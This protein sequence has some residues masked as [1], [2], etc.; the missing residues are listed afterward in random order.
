M[1]DNENIE[2][3]T[4]EPKKAIL[5]LSMP[6]FMTLIMVF[7]YNLVDT[8][9]VAGLG[10]DAL[11][12]IAFVGPI[13]MLVLSIG[14][15]IGA[16][17]SSLI[18]ISIG[19]N[20]HNHANN[21]GLHAILLGGVLSII[22]AL[23]ILLYAKPILIWIG[24]GNVLSYAMDYIH[25]IFLFL[26]VFIYSSIG[27]S[28]FRAEGNVKRATLAV[29]LGGILDII[30]D[31]IFIYTFNLG[32][33]GAAIATVISALISCALMAY[34]VWIKKDN[35]LELTYKD[36]KLDLN[37]IK[38]IISLAIPD[39]LETTIVSALTLLLNFFIIQVS[40]HVSV[41]VFTS[42]MQI[43]QFTTIPLNAIS[44]ALLTVAGVAYGAKN[45]ENLRIAHS[46]SI[47]IGFLLAIVAAIL[48]VIFAPY[49]ATIFSYSSESAGLTPQIAP[50]LCILSLYVIVIP[51]GI[52][53]SALF[54]AIGKGL[55]S[56][57]LTIIKSFLLELVCI[58]LFCF[59]LGWG[60]NG[61]YVGLILG[62]FLGSIVGY[63]WAKVFI[64]N[65]LE[66]KHLKEYIHE[67]RSHK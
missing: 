56:L 64:I 21:I 49:I 34:W 52:M 31:P 30:L 35:Y 50:T 16:G 57:I 37:I 10:P 45:F 67:K 42:S 27:A 63:V 51:H 32:M 18:S 58:Y 46:F 33:K 66:K 5:K 23:L 1:T 44:I 61:I 15:G 24:A 36:F 17:A 13:Y 62:S 41:A 22:P 26:F 19:A 39:T 2:L 7:M 38:E 8:I 4:G 12:A 53:S 40:N 54:Q 55:Y 60:L 65:K 25:I 48:M 20:D 28:F 3:I 14:N 59:I 6:I 47:R 29:F 43:V 9:W 11:S